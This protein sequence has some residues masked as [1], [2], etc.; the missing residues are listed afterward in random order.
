MNKERKKNEYKIP[1]QV[2]IPKLRYT[3]TGLSSKLEST[4][5]PGLQ[6][7]ALQML[8]PVSK[9][10]KIRKL[11]NLAKSKYNK[12]VQPE[13]IVTVFCHYAL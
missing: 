1:T 2:S 7:T 13:K 12:H 8:Y 3:K 11:Q 10:V 5:Y 9:S 4:I 6:S